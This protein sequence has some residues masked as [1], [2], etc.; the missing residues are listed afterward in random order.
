VDAILSDAHSVYPVSA[1]D[2][3][4]NVY[5]GQPAVI[6]KNG[7]VQTLR[8]ELTVYEG[9]AYHASARVIAAA[10]KSEK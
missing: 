6:G 9:V 8:P 7:V 1:W 5:I 4:L 2:E 10:L 3:E